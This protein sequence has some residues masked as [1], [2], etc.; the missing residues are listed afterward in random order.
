MAEAVRDRFAREHSKRHSFC[1]GGKLSILI[2]T[3]YFLNRQKTAERVY[4]AL[5]TAALPGF[6]TRVAAIQGCRLL[7][8]LAD[9]SGVI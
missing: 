6:V 7:L 9:D 5:V 1:F 3:L 2:R 4:G 8:F